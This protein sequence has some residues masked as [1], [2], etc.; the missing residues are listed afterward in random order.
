MLRND[1]VSLGRQV[2]QNECPSILTCSP[3][4]NTF[5]VSETTTKTSSWSHTA[6]VAI[7]VGVE[8]SVGVPFFAESTASISI[9]GSYEHTWGTEE[10]TEQN[11]S[12]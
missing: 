8:F 12:S 9:T 1:P 5:E 3:Q 4:T 6:G 7:E 11:W 10:S 2:V